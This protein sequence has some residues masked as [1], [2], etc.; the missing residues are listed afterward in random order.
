MDTEETLPETHGADFFAPNIP[1]IY[2]NAF[3]ILPN[4]TEMQLTLGLAN[5]PVVRLNMSPITAKNLATSMMKSVARYEEITGREIES[6]EAMKQKFT[7]A[8]PKK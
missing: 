7:N 3:S 2:F 1:E 8:P 5:V 6:F 4:V